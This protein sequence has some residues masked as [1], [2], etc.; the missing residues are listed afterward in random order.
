MSFVFVQREDGIRDYDVSGVQTCAL[1]IFGG[2][3]IVGRGWY[4]SGG[5]W[6]IG[7]Y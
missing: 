6:G 2:G 5:G 1:P 4:G 7:L 3:V